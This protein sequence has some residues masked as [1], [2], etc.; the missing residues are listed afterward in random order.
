MLKAEL[1][2]QKIQCP[3]CNKIIVRTIYKAEID[4]FGSG[5]AN[6][7]CCECGKWFYYD[8]KNKKVIEK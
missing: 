7:P 2:K 1:K 5:I 3:H 6:F 8:T 4:P